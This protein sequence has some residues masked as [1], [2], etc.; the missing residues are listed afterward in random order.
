WLTT[1]LERSAGNDRWH[2]YYRSEPASPGEYRDEGLP[3]PVATQL[4]R[5][6]DELD[7]ASIRKSS[8]IEWLAH[9]TSPGFD[10]RPTAPEPP[11]DLRDHDTLAACEPFRPRWVVLGDTVLLGAHGRVLELPDAPSVRKVLGW[12]ERGVPT[13]V[14]DLVKCDEAPHAATTEFAADV[15]RV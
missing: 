5:L 12:L 13:C 9:A 14:A 6:L 15:K 1:E 4:D 10:L 11:S 3:P 7:I 8:A 2:H